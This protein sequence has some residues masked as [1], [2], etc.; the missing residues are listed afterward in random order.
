MHEF[1]DAFQRRLNLV[2]EAIAEAFFAAA[3]E[4]PTPEEAPAAAKPSQSQSQTMLH[5][6]TA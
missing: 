3:P 4:I 6:T 1:I 5:G 2:G